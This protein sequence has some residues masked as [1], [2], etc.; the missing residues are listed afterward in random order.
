M[1]HNIQLKIGALIISDAHYSKE[2]PELLALIKDIHANKIQTK[3][4]LLM[5]DIFDTLFVEVKETQK[6]N[7][8]LIELLNEINKEIEL[9]YLEGNHDFNLKNIFPD[10][11]VVPLAEQPFKLQY[12][13]KN[14]ALAHG[15]FDIGLAYTLY[16]FLIRNSFVLSFLS[17]VNRL[18]NNFILNKLDAYLRK[19]DDCKEF[20]GFDSYIRNRN[21][22]KYACEYFIEGHYHQNRS[23]DFGVFKYV[24][25]AAFA[26]NQRYFIVKLS[27]DNELDIEE[28]SYVEI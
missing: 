23:F 27:E 28:N 1:S 9:I 14:I 4:L 3:Q 11:K 24:N 2:R 5:G 7:K 16:S 18:T 20:V 10:A 13:N 22:Q 25:L 15:D 12:K 6:Q 17:L 26:C 21:L 8:E 19:K